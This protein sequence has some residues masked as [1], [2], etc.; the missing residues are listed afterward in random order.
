MKSFEL[1]RYSPL[2][3]VLTDVDTGEKVRCV[4]STPD[5]LRGTTRIS[6][7]IHESSPRGNE[8]EDPEEQPPQDG[9]SDSESDPRLEET[10]RVNWNFFTGTWMVYQGEKLAVSEFMPPTNFMRG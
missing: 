6:R 8:S 9:P 5:Y 3:T 1:S 10:G 4:S 2:N 7:Y